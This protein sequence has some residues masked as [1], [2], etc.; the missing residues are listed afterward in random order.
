[1]L[2]I[3]YQNKKFKETIEYTFEILLSIFDI[4][5]KFYNYEELRRTKIIEHGLLISYGKRKPEV[6]CTNHIHIYESYLFGREYLRLESMPREPLN[7]YED[8]PIIYRG[9]GD[10]SGWVKYHREDNVNCVETN[11]DIISSS[12]F[13]VSR[14]EEIVNPVEDEYQRFPAEA[15]LAFR[16]SFLHLPVVNAY[17]ELLGDWFKR[18]DSGISMKKLWKGADFA[19]CLTHDIDE[20]RK[21]RLRP[22]IKHLCIMLKKRTIGK[23]IGLISDYLKAKIRSDPY[24]KFDY[25]ME[26]SDQYGFG[27]SYYFMC[28][29]ETK[30]EKYY[31]IRNRR[32][33][34]LIQKIRDRGFEVGLHS[35]FNA[36]CDPQIL[37][38]EKEK[39]EK[40]LD[41]KIFGVRQHYLLWKTPESWRANKK[42]GFKYDTTMYFPYHE[43]FRGGICF[44]Y[45]S[46]DILRNRTLDIWEVPITV[47]ECTLLL[48]QAL[49]PSLVLKRTKSLIDAVHKYR[50]LFV[51]LWHNSSLNDYEY[52]GAKDVYESILKY[53]DDLK[54]FKGSVWE[55]LQEWKS[56]LEILSDT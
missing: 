46:F 9:E 51:L 15:S 11:I 49:S 28:R 31:D 4:Q 36:C 50:G 21:Y 48:H 16:G 12:F 41:A 1:V 47:M 43:G 5:C 14:Y 56:S 6:S 55:I 34:R 8:I 29:G 45:K 2:Y 10:I 42:A 26:L 7:W 37:K 52:P 17:I 32:V 19:A 25:L 24:N 44:P 18:I 33:I 38:R 13:M 39:I 54:V 20:I 22:P 53:L 23:F 40:S 27:S 30:F 3:A 35:S